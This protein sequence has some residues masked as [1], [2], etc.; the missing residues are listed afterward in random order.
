MCAKDGYVKIPSIIRSRTVIRRCF[1]VL[2]WVH[3]SAEKNSCCLWGE[4]ELRRGKNRVI[5]YAGFS[6]S[7]KA[8]AS[9]L[10]IFQ[11]IYLCC[12]TTGSYLA[13]LNL[14]Q[15]MLS[16]CIIQGKLRQPLCFSSVKIPLIKTWCSSETHGLLFLVC[17]T[18]QEEL[19]LGM[20]WLLAAAQ[21]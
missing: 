7:P 11:A 5:W 12:Y 10:Y 17:M 16:N 19:W 2:I 4:G 14:M 6:L 8:L 3:N 15:K 9:T 20:L 13:L 18:H 1:K 21:Q